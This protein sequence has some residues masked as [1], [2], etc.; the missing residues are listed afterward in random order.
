MD[1]AMAQSL[2]NLSLALQSTE[3]YRS[4]E[5]HPI[6]PLHGL[7]SFYLGYPATDACLL[8]WPFNLSNLM[9][10]L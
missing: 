8:I 5:V 4:L 6:A 9:Y 7:P 2:W 1:A 10:N 3:N